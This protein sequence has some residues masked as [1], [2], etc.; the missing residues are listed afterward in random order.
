MSGAKGVLF[1]I[2]G[3]DFTIHEVYD[4]ARVIQESADPDANIIFGAVIDETMQGE[5]QIT[6]IATGFE[7]RAGRGS[8]PRVT[9]QQPQEPIAHEREQRRPEHAVDHYDVPAFLRKRS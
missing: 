2:A 7:G 5:L 3:G 8:Q 6:V 1:N 9:Q 4:A